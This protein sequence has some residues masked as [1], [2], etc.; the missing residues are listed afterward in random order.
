MAKYYEIPL[1]LRGIGMT[2]GPVNGE[3]GTGGKITPFKSRIEFRPSPLPIDLQ[4]LVIQ[5]HVVEEMGRSGEPARSI[6]AG[7]LLI[8]RCNLSL[9]AHPPAGGGAKPACTGRNLGT[10]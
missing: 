1:P 8:V 4:P 3:A 9:V 6:Q 5:N 2:G 10:K 7:N